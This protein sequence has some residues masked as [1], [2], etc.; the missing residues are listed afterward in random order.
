[1][2]PLGLDREVDVG[3]IAVGRF[4]LALPGLTA[5]QPVP[6]SWSMSA[7]APQPPGGAVPVHPVPR[8]VDRMGPLVDRPFDGSADRRR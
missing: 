2:A 1:M 5:D 4:G 8:E 7:E 6:W 3:A